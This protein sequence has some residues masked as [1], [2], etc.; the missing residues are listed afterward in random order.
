MELGEDEQRYIEGGEKT[1]PRTALNQP[2]VERK[3]SVGQVL[4]LIVLG[5]LLLGTAALIALNLF[6]PDWPRR[7]P[8]P[9]PPQASVAPQAPPVALPV[10]APPPAQQATSPI[11]ATKLML[12][13]SVKGDTRTVYAQWDIRPDEIVTIERGVQVTLAEQTEEAAAQGDKL[14]LAEYQ[15]RLSQQSSTEARVSQYRGDV[16]TQIYSLRRVGPY[17]KL[18]NARAPDR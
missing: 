17:W 16:L 7:K 9:P 2:A 11:E 3:Y 15:Y 10:V 4:L 13:A 12:R 8:L 5:G 14:N 6:F 18:Y 1:R